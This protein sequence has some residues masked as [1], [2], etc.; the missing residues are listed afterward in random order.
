[1]RTEKEIPQEAEI[2]RGEY[3]YMDDISAEEWLWEFIRRSPR[4]RSLFAKAEQWKTQRQNGEHPPVDD[5]DK[6]LAEIR[7]EGIIACYREGAPDEHLYLVID[8]RV[9]SDTSRLTLPKPTVLCKQW[10]KPQYPKDALPL[11]NLSPYRIYPSLILKHQLRYLIEFFAK[12][13]EKQGEINPKQLANLVVSSF[14]DQDISVGSVR[15]TLFMSISRKVKAKDLE[16]E[17][18][19]AIKS[20]LRGGKLR[21]RKEWKYYLM[22]YDLIEQNGFV[23]DQIAKIFQLAFPTRKTEKGKAKRV[24]YTKEDIERYHASAI[25]YIE[26]GKYKEY[27]PF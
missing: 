23:A 11:D 25:K 14:F 12:E 26:K 10:N 15:D 17:I 22:V 16:Q 6:I 27:L 5:L 2:I 18:V 7:A 1:M 19:P 20:C 4:Y 13:Q 24:F 9:F 21:Q 8:T 3:A